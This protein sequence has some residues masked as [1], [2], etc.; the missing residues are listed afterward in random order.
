MSIITITMCQLIREYS[1]Q[2]ILII[3][4]SVFVSSSI[5][6]LKKKSFVMIIFAECT[7]T[8]GVNHAG[9][10]KDRKKKKN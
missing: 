5:S 3:C 10:G 4:S 1:T 7:E 6:F 2:I 8:M 9:S